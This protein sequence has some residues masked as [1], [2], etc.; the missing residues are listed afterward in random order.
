[1]ENYDNQRKIKE[2]LK[3][4]KKLYHIVFMI[5]FILLSAKKILFNNGND[6]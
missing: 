2:E 4:F 3:H 1:M 6:S 5:L